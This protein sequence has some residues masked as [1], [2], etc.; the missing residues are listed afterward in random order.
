MKSYLFE[1]FSDEYY[2][3]INQEGVR[4]ALPSKDSD[5]FNCCWDGVL[6]PDGKFYLSYGSEKGG[7]EY[8]KLNRYDY[9]KNRVEDC[10][11]T[12]D[13]LIA[14]D[15]R[16]PASKLH[17]SMDFMPDGRIICINHTTDK[18]K[19]HPEWLPF[20]YYGHS[21]EGYPGSSLFIYDPQTGT[22]ESH[23][24]IVSFESMYGGRYDPKHHCYWM[25]GYLRGHVYCYDIAKRKVKDLG[26]GCE[27]STFR[28]HLGPDENIYFFTKSGYL[29]KVDTDKKELIETGYHIPMTHKNGITLP[30]WG[31]VN[32]GFNIDKDTILF[33]GMDALPMLEYKISTNTVREYGNKIGA[34]QY[35]KDVPEC[36]PGTIDATMDQYGVLWY[37]TTPYFLNPETMKLPNK[38]FVGVRHL[39]RW[40]YKNS[41]EAECVGAIGVPEN[42]STTTSAIAI[43]NKRDILYIM[44]C[45]DYDKGPMVL[46]IDMKIFRKKYQDRTEKL[47]D[48]R[49]YPHEVEHISDPETPVSYES[50]S[51]VNPHFAFPHK[52]IN[53]VKICRY[54][55]K[56]DIKN[57]PVLGLYWKGNA[58][59]IICGERIPKYFIK[60]ENDVTTIE[61]FSTFTAEKKV[62]ILDKIKPLTLEL[63]K[64]VNLPAVSGRQYL[65]QVSAAIKWNQDK[66]MIGTRD[67]MMALWDGK[68]MFALGQAAPYGPVRAFCTNREKTKLWGVVGSDDCIGR[69]ISYTDTEG[70]R[71]VG[72]L[73]YDNPG[74]MTIVGADVLS[75]IALSD[76]EKYLAIGSADRISEIVFAKL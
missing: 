38:A 55:P 29:T 5:L 26:K 18:A 24:V 32:K 2:T 14:D 3:L 42:G 7:M 27:F 20:G 71:Q 1:A 19:Q 35:I 37:A 33:L 64:G 60:I 46:G 75:A 70:L 53:V 34:M 73:K 21:W 9:D 69:V 65:A 57:S 31:W 47:M 54:L 15:K 56:E 59:C 25:I 74:K 10:L 62:H 66:V 52:N 13:Y 36:V 16:I 23:G 4:Y 40:D 67:G 76:D 50:T 49:F 22:V 72:M 28:L 41:D 51:F 61:Q 17:T 12:R 30:R 39:F 8:A 43:D 48:P 44:S 6:S 45:D 11:L 58:L 63:P 68:N